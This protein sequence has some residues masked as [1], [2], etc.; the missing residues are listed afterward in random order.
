M[1]VNDVIRFHDKNVW[2]NDTIKVHDN[3]FGSLVKVQILET[4][5]T[6]QNYI[7]EEIKE[8]TE[9]EECQLSNLL[10][11]VPYEYETWSLR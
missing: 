9:Y 10:P 5:L 7:Y 4:T 2:Q 8:Q 6:Y 3:W 1:L 11:V